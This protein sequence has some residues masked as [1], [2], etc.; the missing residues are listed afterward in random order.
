MPSSLSSRS[1]L[2]APVFPRPTTTPILTDSGDGVLLK[3]RLNKHNQSDD[4]QSDGK[5]RER[6][7]EV[8][9]EPGEQRQNTRD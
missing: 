9:T 5:E 1:V 6:Q 8:L 4:Y 2:I 7:A 3:E